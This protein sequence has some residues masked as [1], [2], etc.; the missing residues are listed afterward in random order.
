[1]WESG[2]LLAR[3]Y[4]SIETLQHAAEV[5]LQRFILFFFIFLF[6]FI[7]FYCRASAQCFNKCC[8]F[9]SQRLFYFIL[10]KKDREKK[11]ARAFAVTLGCLR[12]TNKTRRARC[13]ICSDVR[14]RQYSLFETPCIL[15]QTKHTENADPVVDC[16]DDE[17]SIRR[18]D[19][20]VVRVSCSEVEVVA[21]YEHKH[22]Q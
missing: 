16:D 10:H 21:V 4:A 12:S 6:H 13:R 8:N 1:M 11:E 2:I 18:Q 14:W 15:E 7:S 22:R 17:A 20:S 5:L 9:L 19:T 3:F